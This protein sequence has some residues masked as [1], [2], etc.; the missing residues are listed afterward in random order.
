MLRSIIGRPY[1]M[2]ARERG[3]KRAPQLIKAAQ[4]AHFMLFNPV[5]RLQGHG[6]NSKRTGFSIIEL[7][8]VLAIISILAAVALPAYGTYRTRAAEAACQA[9][10]T[11][12][13]RFSLA[14][15]HDER[16]P[17]AAPERACVEADD[18]TAIGVSITG[19]PQPPGSKP[20]TCDMNTGTCTLGS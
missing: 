5:Y 13:A 7:M 4:L 10:M 17:A 18:V 6:M 11:N 1:F 8:V 16:T 9:E 3:L 20:T 2:L 15:L 12:Y 14:E 19:R